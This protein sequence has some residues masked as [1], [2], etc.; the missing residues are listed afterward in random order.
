MPS[1]LLPDLWCLIFY[2]ALDLHWILDTSPLDPL[3]IAWTAP[4]NSFNPYKYHEVERGCH[5]ILLVSKE[6]NRLAAPICYKRVKLSREV[7]FVQLEESLQAISTRH[8]FYSALSPARIDFVHKWPSVST[9]N[10]AL[11]HDQPTAIELLS[12]STTFSESVETCAAIQ[13]VLT[14]VQ[15][16]THLGS[17]IVCLR[18]QVPGSRSALSILRERGIT[19]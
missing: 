1:C 3:D 8:Q 19:I 7:D 15:F 13:M 16:S 12:I 10:G 14:R 17:S 6:W 5:P 9:S 18:A 11:F 4:L 2:W